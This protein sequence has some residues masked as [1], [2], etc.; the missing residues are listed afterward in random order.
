MKTKCLKDMHAQSGIFPTNTVF[1]VKLSKG[2]EK[3]YK[4]FRFACV[5]RVFRD[6]IFFR[7]VLPLSIYPSKTDFKVISRV[8]IPHPSSLI[9]IDKKYQ[10]CCPKTFNGN[11]KLLFNTG[12][13][14]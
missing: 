3:C 10:W 7:L 9:L 8:G 5:L 1:R 6:F 13:S 11:L 2:C 14:Y 4:K 12:S